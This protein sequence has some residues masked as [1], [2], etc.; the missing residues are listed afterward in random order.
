MLRQGGHTIAA[1]LVEEVISS[2]TVLMQILYMYMDSV[3]DLWGFF[4]FDFRFLKQSQKQK[5]TQQNEAF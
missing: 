1:G 2:F 3:I 5:K 4:S